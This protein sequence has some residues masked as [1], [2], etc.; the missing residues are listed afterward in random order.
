MLKETLKR[1]KGITLIALVVTIIVLLILAGISINMLTGENGILNRAAESKEK[2]GTTQT[3]ELVKLSVTDA[4]TRG[5]GSLTDEN[6]KAALNS[7]I[8]AG[9][10]E[11][12][13]DATSG[14]TVTVNGKE[15]KID[16][17]GKIDGTTTGG[18]ETGTLPT[19]E[20]TTPY[21]PNGTF[22]KKE[23]DLATGLVIKDSNENEYVWVEVPKTIYSDSKYNAN[24]T[25]SSVDEWEKIR[26]C[27][28]AYT[29]DYSQSS[30]KDTNTD[31]TTYSE[32]YQNMLKSVYTNGGFW[33]GRYEA[34][35][36][37]G[38]N[39]RTSYVAI[40]ENDKAVTKPNM[41]PYN[42][43]RCGEAQTLAKR[44]NYDGVTSS[45]IYG[46][47]WDLVLKFIETKKATAKD[48]LTTNSTAIGNY[49]N[50]LW[51]ITNSKA[52]YSIN[53]GKSFTVGQKRKSEESA[54][55][56]T[57]GADTSFSLMNIYD[58]AGNVLE[59]TREFYSANNP[60]VSRGGS[61]FNGGSNYPAKNRD[62]YVTSYSVDNLGFRL[63][64]WK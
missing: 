24:G 19:G 29:S 49:K 60:C 23:G 7:N 39:P 33:I 12:S 59:W 64:L 8:G 32:D 20:G 63:G 42:W 58:I 45:L 4:L 26:D 55:L 51:N 56:L 17:T 11:I 18:G 22:S 44:M 40:A 43:V 2:T 27:L 9:K 62:N 13:G 41:Y 1:N 30:F 61:Y 25:P 31:G 38:K 52:R 15:Y 16:S 3:E 36:E 21:L 50:N 53:D 48:N 57:T 37:E 10:Y 6:L 46:L 28:K 54:I 34:G 47:Q 35:L 5:T 14:W